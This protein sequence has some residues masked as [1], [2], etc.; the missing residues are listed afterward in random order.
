MFLILAVARCLAMLGSPD[1]NGA[2]KVRE[3][4]LAQQAR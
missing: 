2:K 1:G 3:D 4:T